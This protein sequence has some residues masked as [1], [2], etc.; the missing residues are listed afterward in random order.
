[1]RT[2]DMNKEMA[3]K[4]NVALVGFRT[5]GKSLVGRALAR[6]LHRTF[7]DM[8]AELVVSF[9]LDIDAWVR[10]HGWESFREE[11]SRL[12][13]ELAGRRNLV[14]ATG[15]GVVLKAGNRERL[16]N[17]FFVIWL[18]ASPQTI[19]SRMVHDPKSA[20]NRPPLTDLP[21]QKE[22]E[23]LLLDRNPLY[24]EVADLTL[25]T[26]NASAVELTAEIRRR[27]ASFR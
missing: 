6:K 8:D 23:R 14:V 5:T 27:M 9:G 21:L 18:Q 2:E 3:D 1:M 22:I 24:E 26:D 10:S 17:H 7:V 16:K 20:A 12:L 11:E 15:G 13:E 25:R 4:E 19:H